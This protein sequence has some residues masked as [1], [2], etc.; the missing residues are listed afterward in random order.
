MER[1]FQT[2]L[3]LL[4]PEVVFILGDIFD[5]GKWSSAEDWEDDV[6][7]F[8]QI[9]RHPS[10]TELIV[11]VGNHDIGFHYEMNWDKLRRFEKVF[12][13]SSARIITK[14][15]VNFLL[16]NSVAMH[17]D[18]CPICQAVENELFQLS[19]A[20]NCSMQVHI[21]IIIIVMKKYKHMQRNTHNCK[22]CFK[23]TQTKA[24]GC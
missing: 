19:E 6:R 10:D 7:R 16:V 8:Q 12:N 4:R 17:G 14:K 11:L 20:L 21:I 18:G 2:A 15:G 3:W 22:Q 9:F 13:A 1:A 5:E 23:S 24:M